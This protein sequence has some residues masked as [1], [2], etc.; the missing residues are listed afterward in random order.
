MEYSKEG[1]EF[2]AVDDY[3]NSFIEINALSAVLNWMLYLYLVE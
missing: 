1:Y 3:F 2:L